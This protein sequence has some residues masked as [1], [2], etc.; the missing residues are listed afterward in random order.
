MR[1][2]RQE[3]G[4]WRGKADGEGMSVNVSLQPRGANAAQ[5]RFCVGILCDTETW[6]RVTG[7]AAERR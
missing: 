5:V 1:D 6:T 7:P 4:A 2:L 3:R